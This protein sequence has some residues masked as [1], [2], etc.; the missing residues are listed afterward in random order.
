MFL[1][2]RRPK[3]VSYAGLI[4]PSGGK[5]GGQSGRINDW[6]RCAQRGCWHRVPPGAIHSRPDCQRATW[7]GTA[8][9]PKTHQG[10]SACCPGWCR[11]CGICW[12]RG[13]KSCT[14]CGRC[15]L[16]CPGLC[17]ECGV[18]KDKCAGHDQK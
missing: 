11:R 6:P 1:F 15:I 8:A 16:S 17:A 13:H 18:C 10:G 2:R 14:Q 7:E 5:L 12:D 4:G 3:P 9:I